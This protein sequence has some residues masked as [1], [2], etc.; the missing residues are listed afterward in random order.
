MS[1]MKIFLYEIVFVIYFLFDIF[2]LKFNL[3][4]SILYK[5]LFYIRFVLLNI[6]SIY[7]VLFLFL[8]KRININFLVNHQN[9]F[10]YGHSLF[11]KARFI[12]GLLFIASRII[13]NYNESNYNKY[14][15]NCPFTFNSN[16]T[17]FNESIYGKRRCELYNINLNS[18]YKYQYICSYDASQDFI[19]D[20]TKDGFDKIVCV[21]KINNI[22]GNNIIKK[23]SKVFE[24]K[25]NND[26]ELFY[27]S[28]IHKPKKNEYIKDEYCKKVNNIYLSIIGWLIFLYDL[29]NLFHTELNIN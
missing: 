28:R 21:S 2:L 15:K 27:C 12:I 24:N 7:S 18:R 3:W 20:K 16:I 17:N 29:I 14:L 22:K 25:D 13:N 4:T 26:N 8:S 5:I 23:F 11:S 10:L 19:H 1:K 6:Y 9:V